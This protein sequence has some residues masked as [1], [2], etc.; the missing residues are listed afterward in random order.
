MGEAEE[1]AKAIQE[2]AKLGTKGLGTAEKAGE[3]IAKIFKEPIAEV[4]GLITDKLRLV[5]WKRMVEMSDEVT[6][7]L[8]LRKITDTRPVP[9]K[10]AF[11]IIEEASLEEDDN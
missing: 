2:S 6:K 4:S 7:I 5:Q 3:F 1:I 11:T 9:P 8:E 10:L